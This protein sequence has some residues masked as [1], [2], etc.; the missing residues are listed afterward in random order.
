M[1]YSKPVTDLIK[2]RFSC[3]S[4]VETDIEGKKLTELRE[5]LS[6]QVKGPL[7]SKVRFDILSAGMHEKGSIN[8]L[9]T[10]GFIRG[11]SYYI[12]GAVDKSR[13]NLEDY[14]Y[15]MEKIILH[16]TDMGLGTCWL[17]GS[18]QKS[19][20]S[21]RI[22]L[23]DTEILPAI[24]PIGYRMEKPAIFDAIV[25]WSIK[26]RKR[27]PWEELFFYKTFNTPLMQEQAGKYAESL[28][29]VR[30][31]PS[32][33]NWQPWRIIKQEDRDVF[34]FY[35]I[36]KN[37]YTASSH[38]FNLADIQRLDIGIAMCHFDLTSKEAGLKGK[39]TAKDPLIPAQGQ[40][41]EYI[42]SWE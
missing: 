24:S 20:F 4:Y 16:A 33:S 30:L 26:A 27:K 11:A 40:N 28:E 9:A 32:G 7:G 2:Q 8:A 5:Y 36:R 31:A 22:S 3:R 19:S 34:H 41:L 29:M 35:I 1:N 14:G 42:I 18:F 15:L 10:Y 25:R 38:I 12:A 6:S 37:A 39:W 13:Y 17:G 21:R 23:Q